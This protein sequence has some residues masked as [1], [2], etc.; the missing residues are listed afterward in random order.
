M[1]L[2]L[3]D[4]W[5][6]ALSDTDLRLVTGVDAIRQHL[7]QRLK[8]F[9]LEWFLDR[10]KGVPYIQAVLIKNPNPLAVAAVFKSEIIETPGIV[11][12]ISFDLQIDPG[13]RSL[14]LTF[15][16]AVEDGSTVT[17]DEVLP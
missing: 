16:A 6:L 10:R 5:D 12:L 4:N 11:E 9:L 14:R 1:D 8:T 13:V 2:L 7:I 17:V 15:T 3:D